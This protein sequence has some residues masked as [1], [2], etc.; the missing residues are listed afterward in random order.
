[1]QQSKLIKSLQQLNKEEIK[2]FDKFLQSPYYNSSHKILLFY[3]ILCKHYK[4]GFTSARLKKQRIFDK[5]YPN[6][7]CFQDSNIRNLM[8]LLY[9]HLQKFVFIEQIQ[10]KESF[11]KELLEK[12]NQFH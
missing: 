5:V 10:Q 7:P 4:N 3:R 12:T 9:Q 2:A 6:A 1:M 11:F 8:T